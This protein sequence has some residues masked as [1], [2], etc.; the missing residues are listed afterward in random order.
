[1]KNK[2]SE[3][4]LTINAIVIIILAFTILGLGLLFLRNISNFN[5][6]TDVCDEWK[7]CDYHCASS[8][9]ENCED[10]CSG[11][12]GDVP[13]EVEDKCISWHP[14]DK[15]ELNPNA[16]GCICDEKIINSN[17]TKVVLDCKFGLR[18]N[19]F[20][21]IYFECNDNYKQGDIL[22]VAM[23]PHYNL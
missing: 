10:H 15:C 18:V 21:S 1:M 7:H 14:K 8:F 2:K 3:L 4:A 23:P 5:P 22:Y 6:A 19:E 9:T 17:F 20:N 16:E 11:C 13:L 12:C